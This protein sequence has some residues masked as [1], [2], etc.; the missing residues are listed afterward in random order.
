[1]HI[2][3]GV[4]N[5]SKVIYANVTAVSALTAYLPAL[6]RKPSRNCQ[7]RAC[8]RFLLPVHGNVPHAGWRLPSCISWAPRRSISCSASCPRCSASPS[9]F[10]LQGLIFEPQDLV[11]LGVN[12][13]SLMVPL[14]AVHALRGRHYFADRA[15]KPRLSWA[16]IVKFDAAYYAGVVGMVGFWLALGTEVTPF[17]S[18]ALFAVSYVPLVLCEPVFTFAV[19]KLLGKLDPANPVRKAHG[20]QRSGH[21]LA[22]PHARS[23]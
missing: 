5:A 13:L 3:P 7:D 21:R 15:S 18:W 4:L 8:R 20:R 1:M 12:S 23:R 22:A 19:L 2:E 10:S 16:E 11:H 6:L 17:A 14:I 9:A